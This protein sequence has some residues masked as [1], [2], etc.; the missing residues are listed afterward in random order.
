MSGEW[1]DEPSITDLID[2]SEHVGGI[3]SMEYDECSMLVNDYWTQE[4]GGLPR[5]SLV[6]ARPMVQAVNPEEEGTAADEWTVPGEGPES[7]DEESPVIGDPDHA[8][9]LRVMGP[10]EL[11]TETRL[12]TNRH[13]AIRKTATS[14]NGAKPS[15]EDVADLLTRREM[16][17]SGVTAKVLGT[18][19][20]DTPK[21]DEPDVDELLRYGSDIQNVL[22]AGNYIVYKLQDRALSWVSSYPSHRSDVQVELGEVKYTSTQ[23]WDQE[24]NQPTVSIP[25]EDFI[26]AK[27]ALFGM[28]RTGKSNAMKVLATA[29][30][31]TDEPVG[32]LLF[33]PSGEYAYANKQDERALADLG[34]ATTIYKYGAQDDEENVKQLRSNLLD[35]ENIEIA[36]TRVQQLLVDE[37]SN[38]IRD[39]R[40]VKPPR[41]E[42]IVNAD[43]KSEKERAKRVH[44]A[45][46]ALLAKQLDLPS[47][48][49]AEHTDDVNYPWLSIPD[50]MVQ[51]IQDEHD[52]DV[53]SPGS[54]D[55]RMDA[56]TLVS[57]WDAVAADIKGFN[58]RYREVD[59][60]DKDWVNEEL[61]KVLKMF[62]TRSQS[63]HRLLSPL[64]KFHNPKSEIDAAEEIYTDLE[65]G[66]IVVVDISN[67]TTDV[68]EAETSRITRSILRESM[69]RFQNP[70]IDDDNLPKIQL[71]L[72]EAHQHFDSEQY[73]DSDAQNPYVQL[74]KEGAKFR[75]GLTYATQ[76]VT[77]IDPRVLSN[78]ANWII[79]HLNSKHEI[80]E[81]SKYYNF[82]DFEHSI[83]NVE[84][85]GFARVKTD[86]GEYIIS[87]K[88]SLFN[89]RWIQAN[90]PF[91]NDAETGEEEVDTDSAADTGIQID[92]PSEA[93]D[94]NTEAEEN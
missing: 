12:K 63:G 17:Y 46:L 53:P 80:N 86:S 56:S 82:E 87:T 49:E 33:D 78:T 70:E 51:Y 23:I 57:F 93:V 75:I 79:T 32:Q 36:Y 6:L 44:F 14:Q 69:S 25:V 37:T 60:R 65:A 64:T 92:I 41:V 91:L 24:T 47:D 61:R 68:V 9:L 16:Q 43:N 30:E 45:Y 26:G 48:W 71:Y 28:T 74:A 42:D 1:P 38:Y 34:D 88:I 11:P 35:P 21:D 5:H 67:G 84:D 20:Y 89:T 85:V 50:E 54:N 18:F 15:E 10:A 81:L 66:E 90:T 19:Y 3:F 4:A 22:S 31:T 8:M 59:E 73:R 77:D 83:R 2:H 62:D 55:L 13:D 27:T 52:A 39:F 29:I 94:S 76:E 40:T 72:E 58:E 7:V